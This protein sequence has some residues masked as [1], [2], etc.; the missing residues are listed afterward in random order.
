MSALPILVTPMPCVL[1]PVVPIHVPVM[2]DSME[3][4]LLAKVTLKLIFASDIIT[5]FQMLMSVSQALVV[6]MLGV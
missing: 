1:T 4:D 3:M 2:L 5:S 6:P